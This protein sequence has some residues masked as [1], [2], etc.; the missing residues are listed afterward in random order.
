MKLPLPPSPKRLA[1][2]ASHLAVRVSPKGVAISPKGY[3]DLRPMPSTVIDAGPQRTIHHYKPGSAERTDVPPVLL[4]PPLAAPAF[5]FDLR[6]GCSMVEH[7]VGIGRR[8]YLVDYGQIFFSDRRLGIEHWVDDVL[9]TGIATVSKHSGG[10]PVHLVAWCLGGI[11]SLLATA[12]RGDL[13]IASVTSVAAP[14]DMHAVP[15]M[16]PM[17]PLVNLTGGRATTALYRAF[18]GIPSQLVQRGFQLSTVDKYLSKPL[19]VMQNQD[20]HDFLAQIEAVDHFTANMLAYPGRTYGQLFHRFFRKNDLQAGAMDLAGR[21][22]ELANVR[23]PVLVVAGKDDVLAP[24][25]AVERLV[26]L[27]TG[28]PRVRFETAPGGHLGVLTGRK[29][30][31][32]TWKYIDQFLDEVDGTRKGAE[33]SGNGDESDVE[34]GQQ[35]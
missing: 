6:R 29:A 9:P 22:I 7:L 25:R 26:A 21:R 14:F 10:G 30:R 3:A 16:A 1:E 13:P 31:H 15:L 33:A 28:A 24:Q 18:G 8:T 32:T 20:D 2:S 11:F 23:V 5:C 27:L 12:D 34:A 35:R 4:V 17:R 19:V